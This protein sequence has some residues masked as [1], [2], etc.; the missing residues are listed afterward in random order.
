MLLLPATNP[1][2]VLCGSW[3]LY[4]PVLQQLFG[5]RRVFAHTADIF[6][7]RGIARPETVRLRLLTALLQTSL[8]Q[9][10]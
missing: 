6:F 8:L 5:Y 7:Q 1:S 3:C 4:D 2:N 9:Q 10:K